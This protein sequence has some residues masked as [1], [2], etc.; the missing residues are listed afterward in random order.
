MIVLLW[1]LMQRL[2]E[3]VIK[4]L[5]RTLESIFSWCDRVIMK[6][7]LLYPW[8]FISKLQDKPL[9]DKVL[10]LFYLYI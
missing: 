2:G 8:N 6:Q 5:S 4:Y 9:E 10:H 7:N 3:F 1:L